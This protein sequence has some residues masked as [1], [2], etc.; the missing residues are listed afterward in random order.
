MEL[1]SVGE[2]KLIEEIKKIVK[3]RRKEV[4]G[5]IGDDSCILSDNT[6]LTTDAFVQGVHFDLSYMSFSDVG[7]RV[8]GATLSDIAAMGAEPLCVLVSLLLPSH[9]KLKEVLE[10]Y[11]GMEEFA[12]KFNVEIAGGEV[13]NSSLFSLVLTALGKTEHPVLRKG[14]I[15]GDRVFI[16]GEVGLAEA[17]RLALKNGLDKEFFQ[18]AMKKHLSPIP[19]I[20]EA[21]I[22]AP[23]VSSLIDTSDGLSTDSFHLAQESRVKIKIFFNNLPI[24]RETKKIST[25]LKIPLEN[26]LLNSGEDYELLFTSSKNIPKRVLKTKITEIGRVEKGEGV[27]LI[28]DGREKRIKPKGYEHFI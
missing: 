17:G 2:L 25:L 1:K 27:W 7:R 5:G 22:I 21:R 15:S 10:L 9:F 8:M 18:R 20:R 16:T 11:R 12:K 26:F 13:V 3:R 24:S 4:I 14:A 6:V 28:K 19:R 23:S